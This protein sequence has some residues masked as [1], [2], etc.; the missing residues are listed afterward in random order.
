MKL[1]INKK[2]YNA[3]DE[4]IKI[5]R[6]SDAT[7]HYYDEDNYSYGGSGYSHDGPS[8]DLVKE[9]NEYIE[10]MNYKIQGDNITLYFGTHIQTLSKQRAALLY[11][12]LHK[13]LFDS[14]QERNNTQDKETII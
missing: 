1:Q 4:I 2:Y 7:G 5:V 14:S 8:N 10:G 6:Y 3:A 11:I 9:V 12:E 13:F